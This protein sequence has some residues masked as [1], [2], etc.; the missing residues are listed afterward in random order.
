MPLPPALLA[1]LKQR[2][3]VSKIRNDRSEVPSE[4]KS[5]VEH[6]EVFAENYD[7]HPHQ[8]DSP[9]IG[10]QQP[11]T[12]NNSSNDQIENTG[13]APGCPNKWNVH[14]KCVPFCFKRWGA[15]ITKERK[16]I[17]QRR[18]RMLRKFPLPADWS[19]E[20]D[21]GAGRHYYWHRDG[22]QVSWLSPSH[23]R[24]QITLPVPKFQEIMAIEEDHDE[25][26]DDEDDDSE[27]SDEEE[28]GEE[29]P[30]PLKKPFRYGSQAGNKPS[31]R[32]KRRKD[33]GALDPMDPASYS[34]TCPRGG[35]SDGLDREGGKAA[36]ST[37]SGPL[38][39]QRPYPSP[40][41]VLR[42][43]KK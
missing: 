4:K 32:R 9:V 24:S 29:R 19:E 12:D 37:A 7:T 13:S 1:R 38:F 33:D 39:Q 34:D 16:N 8:K 31:D 30:P 40:G 36:D 10:P 20:F 14:H 21:A 15:G 11:L 27:N 35:W 41:D 42:M 17:T 5:G 26:S 28:Q 2:G 18:L 25:D 6:E 43:K 22:K 3:I 23:P